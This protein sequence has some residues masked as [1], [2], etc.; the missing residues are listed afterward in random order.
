VSTQPG[1]RDRR[2][3]RNTVVAAVREVVLVVVLA[4]VLATLIRVFLVQA[5]VIPS[6][7]M[8][9][10]LQIDD[11]V[12]V[13]KL[14]TRVSD[15]Q[16]GQVIVFEDPGGW[17]TAPAS[18][19]Q[20]PI[21][22]FLQFVGIAPNPSEGHLVKRIIGVGGDQVQCCDS[23]GRLQINGVSVD[24]SQVIRSGEEPSLT[25]FEITVPEGEFWV[26]GDNRGNSG[27]S[28]INGTVPEGSVVGPVSAIAWPI[29]RWQR[30]RAPEVYADVPGGS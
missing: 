6:G 12:L 5:F 15:V 23:Q 2:R 9:E 19:D 4:L 14:T 8:L 27:D 1:S 10:T 18:T 28:R 22:S 16:R 3:R 21:S 7:S 29:D 17:L 20:S 25:E 11:R 24:E 26:M 13:N 30:V